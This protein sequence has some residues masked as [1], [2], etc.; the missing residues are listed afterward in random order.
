[1]APQY[2]SKISQRFD[3]V[4]GCPPEPALETVGCPGSPRMIPKSSE[5][6][7]EQVRLDEPESP[8]EELRQ[9]RLLPVGEVRGLF[10]QTS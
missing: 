10:D 7:L 3:T 5:Q 6:P 4:M 9:S 1:M 8:F 2:P